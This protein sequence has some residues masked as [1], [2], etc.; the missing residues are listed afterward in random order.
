M[1]GDVRR[2]RLGAEVVSDD[3]DHQVAD[4]EAALGERA[5]AGPRARSARRRGRLLDQVVEELLD[6]GV[7]RPRRWPARTSARSRAPVNS[8]VPP[9]GGSIGAGGVDRLA[10]LLARGTGRR[11]RSSPGAKP[12]GLIIPW[13]VTARRGA[14]LQGRRARG[15]SGRRGGRA[16]SG[17]TASGGGRSD[18]P[19]TLRARKTPAVDRRAR[20]GVGER[21]QQ[22]RV[23]EHPGPLRRLERHLLE[24]RVGREVAA[25][26]LREPAVEE[27]RS[28]SRSWRKSDE[29]PQT[30]SSRKRSSEVRRSAATAASNPGKRFRV[31]GE[32]GRRSRPGATGGRTR[33]AW[34]GPG[35]RR[36]SARPA[37]ATCSRV[38]SWSDAAAS[39]RA[40][41]GSESQSPNESREAT[42]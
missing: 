38:A 21:R 40:R 34:P 25:V 2:A 20:R 18:R 14:G 19:R 7:V 13:Q 6:E 32:V 5:G 27:D 29:S 23:R 36:P 33:G 22:V 1:P 26:E 10:L 31:L 35:G 39:S 37:P 9:S 12:S 3:L 11:R 24:R 16:A 8:T 17:V 4:V 28:P 30:T 15:S 42:S 41:S